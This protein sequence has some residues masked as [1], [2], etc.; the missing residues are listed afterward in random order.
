MIHR[1][2][3]DQPLAPKQTITVDEKAFHHLVHV[4][5]IKMNE[6]LILFNGDGLDYVSEVRSINKKNIHIDILSAHPN[7]NE[8]PLT[9]HLAQ[10]IARG[11]KMDLIIQKAV[12]LG[13][14]TIA[15]LI[16][17]RCNVKLTEERSEK[18]FLHWQAIIIRAAEQ[19][20][21]SR[22][23]ILLPPQHLST[24]LTKQDTDIRFVLSPHVETENIHLEKNSVSS[25][26]LLIGPEGGLSDTEVKAATESGF[27]PLCLGP[28]ILR[29]ETASLAAISILQYRFGDF[30]H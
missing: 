5:R 2:Y 29:T 14:N 24:Y 3:Q 16:T 21:R 13:V 28:R 15:P 1:I 10:A 19:S 25:I 30:H 26:S 9:I 7:H 6:P 23:P 8:S 12:E 4:L 22:L 20:G 27:I 11:E 18:R 17:E